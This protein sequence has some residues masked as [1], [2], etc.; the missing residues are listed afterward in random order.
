MEMMF[1]LKKFGQLKKKF[2]NYKTKLLNHKFLMKHIKNYQM[3]QRD[4]IN[5]KLKNRLIFNGIKNLH[6]FMIPHSLNKPR[7]SYQTFNQLMMLIF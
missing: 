3:V 5:Y 6:I 1:F 4:G 7:N 2:K